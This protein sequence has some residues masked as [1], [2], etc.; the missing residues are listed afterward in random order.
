MVNGIMPGEGIVE[1]FYNDSWGTI[2]D[3]AWDSKDATVVCKQLG[4]KFGYA[5][6]SAKF[7]EGQGPIYMD[8]V[9]C[10]GKETSLLKCQHDGWGKHDCGHSEDSSVK[11]VMEAV[12]LVDGKVSNEGRVEV[13]YND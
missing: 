13:L 11:C 3:D 2:C 9:N 8:S 10:I 5:Y 1:V 4:F 7:G 12:R 6:G